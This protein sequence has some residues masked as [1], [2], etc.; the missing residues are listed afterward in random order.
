[1]VRGSEQTSL[2]RRIKMAKRK[3]ALR[4]WP[5]G[6]CKAQAVRVPSRLL[7]GVSPKRSSRECARMCPALPWGAGQV[8]TARGS[9]GSQKQHGA[10]AHHPGLSRR[11]PAAREAAR[12]R[13][14]SPPRAPPSSPPLLFS[15]CPSWNSVSR[16]SSLFQLRFLQESAQAP[17]VR[18]APN[19][20][21]HK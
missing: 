1:M 20:Y 15:S 18:G 21:F 16:L 14:W 11:V 10:T 3:D 5:S 6:R 4:H 13:V 7:G 19:M 17:C 9:S 8:Q 2:Q 12:A